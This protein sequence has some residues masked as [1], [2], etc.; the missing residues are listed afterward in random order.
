[1]NS[2]FFHHATDKKNWTRVR[3]HEFKIKRSSKYLFKFNIL[4]DA[5]GTIVPS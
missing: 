1:M 3:R 2:G 4:L 5:E